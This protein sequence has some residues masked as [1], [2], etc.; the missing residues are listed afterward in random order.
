MDKKSSATGLIAKVSDKLNYVVEWLLC[1]LGIVMAVVMTIQVFCRYVLN[2]SLFWSEE[3]GRI[4]L[5]WLSFL[6]ATSAYKRHLHI[7]IDFLTRKLP[8]YQQKICSLLTIIASCYFY[9]VLV[10]FGIKFVGFVSFQKTAAIG[11]PMSVTYLVIPISGFIFF[12]HAF[13][14][15]LKIAM[16]LKSG[17]KSSDDAGVIN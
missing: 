6:G 9:G 12:I 11:L 15:F 14:H 2:H 1:F 7:G 16:E 5:V 8:L 10:Y 17:R 3:F 13:D 4:C